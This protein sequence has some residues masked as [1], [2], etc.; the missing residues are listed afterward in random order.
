MKERGDEAVVNPY[1]SAKRQ[2]MIEKQRKELFQRYNSPRIIINDDPVVPRYTKLENFKKHVDYN[3]KIVVVGDGGCGKTC[4]LVSYVHQKFPEVYV[5]TVF[6][7]Y[8]AHI[9]APGNKTIE[10]ALWDTAGQEEYDRLRPLSYPDVDVLLVCFSLDSLTS[11]Q[12]IKDTWYPEVSHFCP[13]VPIVLV[14]TKSDLKSPIHPDIPIELATE[15]NAVGYI[16]CS[17]KTMFNIHTVFNFALNHYQ[18]Q[19]EYQEQVERSSKNRLSRAF[20]T[21]SSSNGS[22]R[23]H[24]YKNSSLDSALL[25][26][27]PLAEDDFQSNPYGNFGKENKVNEE[28]FAFIRKEKKKRRCTIL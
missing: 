21:K 20:H 6:E 12:N 9:A 5:P 16:Q 17:A 10:L 8:V 1:E 4:L 25:L 7:N 15:I 23:R 11:L 28:E 19:Q 13:N 24:H 3:M 22:N 27:Q 18:R 14:G 2:S 26:E